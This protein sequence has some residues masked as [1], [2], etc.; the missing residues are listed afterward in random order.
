MMILSTASDLGMNLSADEV[1]VSTPL[2]HVVE[3]STLLTEHDAFRYSV[4]VATL[5]RC[6]NDSHHCFPFMSV[7]RNVIGP[8]MQVKYGDMSQLM[9]NCSEKVLLCVKCK[10]AWIKAN[11]ASA[12]DSL[13]TEAGTVDVVFDGD[14]THVD[15]IPCINF[16]DAFSNL[17]INAS[18][19]VCCYCLHPY[20]FH[21][22]FLQLMKD[23]I[24]Q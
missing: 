7:S 23:I 15:A 19:D 24:D 16:C 13:S 4:G 11:C 14:W 20:C 2:T 6:S 8:R 21:F 1:I 22:Y 12:V 10:E 5:C 3:L 17:G 9:W 18:L